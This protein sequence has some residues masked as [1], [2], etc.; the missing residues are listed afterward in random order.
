M[1]GIVGT[2]TANGHKTVSAARSKWFETALYVDTLRGDHSTGI[3]L[4]SHDKDVT[5]FKKAMPGFDFIEHAKF[6]KLNRDLE[7]FPVAIGHNRYATQ[8]A[9]TAANAHPFEFGNIVLVHNGTLKTGSTKDLPYHAVDSAQI[10]LGL[11]EV[12]HEDT[13]AIHNFL[14]SLDGA[15][16]LVWYNKKT[17]TVYMARNKERP[18]WIGRCTGGKHL[19]FASEPWMIT[20][21]GGRKKSTISLA[22]IKDASGDTVDDLRELPVGELQQYPVMS[23]DFTDVGK[24][25]WSEFTPKPS[26]VYTGGTGGGYRSTTPAYTRNWEDNNNTTNESRAEK[27]AT[28]RRLKVGDTIEGQIYALTKHAGNT[29][30]YTLY[31]YV[32]GRTD[33][34]DSM[35]KAEWV[36]F[37]IYPVQLPDGITEAHV[38]Q[39]ALSFECNIETLDWTNPNS[40]AMT[41]KSGKVLKIKGD[42]S[43]FVLKYKSSA[44]EVRVPQKKPANS[45]QDGKPRVNLDILRSRAAKGCI[46]C[47]SNKI[48]DKDL[49]GDEIVWTSGGR[50]V[51]PTCV[52]D[53]AETHDGK[54]LVH[55]GNTND[56]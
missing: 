46:Q 52:S 31:G 55:R 36:D 9:H 20:G 28:K 7:K 50:C 41:I 23:E 16:A 44:G 56:N 21:I 12:D 18:L 32:N 35:D 15:Y 13:Q 27:E 29:T 48:T 6:R 11:N 37:V 8:G 43:T 42:T 3:A 2:L 5:V 22:Q 19:M 49:L 54:I 10:A 53:W 38:N 45:T 25:W 30:N 51:C 24:Y 14:E 4:V 26:F 1:C 34:L 47:G 33:G 17:G 39:M 40:R